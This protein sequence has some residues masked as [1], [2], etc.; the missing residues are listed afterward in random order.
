MCK[1]NIE[2]EIPFETDELVEKNVDNVGSSIETDK[3]V[4]N[5]LTN[6][7]SN[8]IGESDLEEV[9]GK[10]PQINHKIYGAEA[11]ERLF[12][13]QHAPEEPKRRPRFIQIVT[14][15][16]PLHT[17]T[18]GGLTSITGFS[19]YADNVNFLYSDNTPKELR[20]NNY[21]VGENGVGKLFIKLLLDAILHLISK[22]DEEGWEVD[23]K[24]KKSKVA[25]GERKTDERPQVKIR[26]ISPNITK[27]ELNQLGDESEGK[28]LFLY[29]PEPDELD[30][31]KGGRY[32][33]QHFEVLKKADDEKNTAGQMRAGS[34]SVSAKYNLRLNYVIE[35]RPTQLLDFFKGEIVNGARDRASI[36]EIQAPTDKRKWPKMGDLGEKYQEA[37]RPY[38]DNIIAAKGTIVCKRALKLI[39]KLRNEF[40][41]YYDETQDDVLEL[42]THRALCRAFKRACLIFIADGQQW[43]PALD[44]WI[45][46]S[47]MYDMWQQFHYFYEAICE[48]NRGLKV[49]SIE[50]GP[51]SMRK[52]LPQVFTFEQLKQ[53]YIK[54]G[55]YVDDE[56]IHGTIRSWINRGY[57]ERTESGEYRQL[58]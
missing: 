36:C 15:P 49:T 1:T 43:D 58:K 12:A 42:M 21:V 55:K 8:L 48:A 41:E 3:P 33:R 39:T 51:K 46:W 32:G 19:T 37:I 2:M 52:L 7:P 38:I 34:K 11:Y 30:T 13:S 31:L 56:N 17:Q 14:K 23:K 24:Y 57:I 9:N 16:L 18:A 22:D 47:F 45:R 54:L 44:S 53:L 6:L 27:P 40:F 10:N 35:I 25:A 29:V 4:S 20:T 26:L 50:R 28:P 5:E